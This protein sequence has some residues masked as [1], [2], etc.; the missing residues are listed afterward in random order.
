MN[1]YILPNNL[2]GPRDAFF[3]TSGLKT[4]VGGPNALYWHEF[5]EACKRAGIE[6]HT[7]DLWKREE[8]RPDDTLIVIN[9]P[10]ETFFWRALYFIKYF[11]QKGGAILARRRWL[12]EHYGSFAKRVLV[13]VEPPVS[14]PYVYR[15]LDA[16]KKSGVY[17]K[18]Y[19]DCKGYGADVGYFDYFKDWN[20]DIASPF[21]DAPKNKFLVLVNGNTAPHSLVNEFYGERLK[22]I[23]YFSEAPGFDLYGWRWNKIP[24]HPFFFHYGNY[25]K[26]VWRG[27]IADKIKVMSDYKFSICFENC[28]VPGFVSEKIYDSLAAGCIP[29]YLGAPDIAEIV[30]PECFIDFRK[31]SA[32]GGKNY[33]EL[34]KFLASMPE[35]RIA[36]YRRAIRAFLAS[37]TKQGGAD[38]FLKEILR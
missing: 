16:I 34:H 32:G 9:H 1:I 19:L 4:T 5:R 28:A 12:N 11:K 7:F 25:V 24:K 21:F 8:A 37:R 20:K 3:D 17:T 26:R 29:V 14:M 23:R 30:P 6:A 27:E 15:R 18:I 35:A 36:E 2:A 13:Q 33:A 31:F 38:I 10:G 22:A